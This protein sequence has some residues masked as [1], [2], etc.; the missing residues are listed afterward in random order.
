MYVNAL[1]QLL[2]EILGGPE[3]WDQSPSVFR[4]QYFGCTEK[5]KRWKWKE[6]NH[7]P[8]PQNSSKTFK[9]L[10][11]KGNMTVDAILKLKC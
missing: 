6:I 10:S 7:T 5:N 1:P 2:V 11:Q 4:E 3:R 8:F 9:V